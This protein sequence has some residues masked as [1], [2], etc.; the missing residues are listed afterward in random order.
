MAIK[1]HDYGSLS[2]IEID[3]PRLDSS[4]APDAREAM[5]DL[6]TPDR[7][8]YLVDMHK[9]MF[10]DSSGVGALV[11]FVKFV[12]RDRKVEL[13][14]LTPMVH[15]VFRLTNLLSIFTVHADA[16]QGLASHGAV[17]GTALG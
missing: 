12:G 3:L 14:G 8:V 17:P 5:R 16:G 11:G 1:C 2:V 13:C 10:V 15:K 6:V 4:N 7:G 9:V